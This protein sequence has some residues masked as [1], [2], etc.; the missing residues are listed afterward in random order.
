MSRKISERSRGTRRTESLT[1]QQRKFVKEMLA[2]D[3][4][5]Q[6]EAAKKAGYKH[7]SQAAD[8]LM[9][10]PIIKSALGKEIAERNERIQKTGDDVLSI[11]HQV[12]SFDVTEIF[13][14]QG[15]TTIAQLKKLPKPVRQCIQA[16]ETGVK[17]I[18]VGEDAREEEYIK[19]KWMSKDN[20][21]ELAMKH[22]GLLAPDLHVH[23]VTDQMKAQLLVELL[24]EMSNE[25]VID[26]EHVKR[27]AA[28]EVEPPEGNVI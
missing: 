14:D 3:S 11:L 21:L 15:C 4:M 16:I 26:A 13:D 23:V 18:G 28:G 24:G 12:L 1:V 20:A 6:T 7:P 27:I 5:S 2:S 10:N 17:I 25:T 8:N 19:V 22:H 9:K